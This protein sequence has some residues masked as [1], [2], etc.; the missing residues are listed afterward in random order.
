MR[1]I[2]IVN[3]GLV[4]EEQIVKDDILIGLTIL[5]LLTW[6]IPGI[7]EEET[8]LIKGEQ[9]KIFE[10]KVV[11]SRVYIANKTNYNI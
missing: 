7:Q 5:I 9:K 8:I 6:Q 3:W 4:N 1:I 2:K 11:H 10:F